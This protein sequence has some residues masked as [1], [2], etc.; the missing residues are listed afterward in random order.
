MKKVQKGFTLIELMIVV[1][2]IGI[3]AA[4]A[5]PAYQNYSIRAAFAE[6]AIP[7]VFVTAPTAFYGLGVPDYLVERGF[8]VDKPS[9]LRLHSRYNALVRDHFSGDGSLVLDLET[10]FSGAPDPELA[11]LFTEDKIHLSEPGLRAVADRVFET[12]RSSVEQPRPVGDAHHWDAGAADETR[13]RNFRRDR[14][15]L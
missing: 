12:L 1:A 2:I 6:R 14:P 9:G 11:T 4:V 10:E 5:L 3:L 8:L 7:V 13:T 15:V